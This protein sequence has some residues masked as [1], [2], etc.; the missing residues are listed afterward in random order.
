[1]DATF[2]KKNRLPD[3]SGILGVPGVA[4]LA[5][6]WSDGGLAVWCKASGLDASRWCHPAKPEDSDGLH[7]WLATRPTGDSH[8]TGRFCRRLAILPTGG[9]KRADEPVAVA[10]TIPRASEQPPPLPADAIR[11]TAGLRRDG[12]ELAAGISSAA[13]PGWDPAE[14]PVLGF[15]AAIVDRRMGKIPLFA[16]PEYPWESDPTTWSFLKLAE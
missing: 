14:Q 11:V 7:L 13:L 3:F 4:E 10:G 15:F 16:P 12:W 6:G 1:V 9:G 8:R 5:I 2:A